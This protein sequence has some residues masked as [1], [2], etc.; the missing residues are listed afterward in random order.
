MRLLR[1]HRNPKCAILV[2]CIVLSN[3]LLWL[4]ALE[5]FT[6]PLVNYILADLDPDFPPIGNSDGAVQIHSITK[7]ISSSSKDNTNATL[8][9]AE[10]TEN[11]IVAGLG[12]VLLLSSLNAECRRRGS[13]RHLWAHVAYLWQDYADHVV[14]NF[15]GTAG[16]VSKEGAVV[17]GPQGLNPSNKNVYTNGVKAGGFNY[18]PSLAQEMVAAGIDIISTANNHAFDR[19]LNGIE[20]TIQVIRQQ[21]AV[22]VGTLPAGQRANASWEKWFTVS[23]TKGVRI[24]WIGC[25]ELLC[26]TCRPGLAV[27]EERVQQQ[28]LFCN[29]VPRLIRYIL[30]QKAADAII[31]AAHWG[32]QFKDT[33][34]KKVVEL[35]KEILEAGAT[36]IIGNHAHVMQNARHYR[37]RDGRN[38]YVFY[39]LGSLTSGLGSHRIQFKRRA[40]AVA[41]LEIGKKDGADAYEVVEVKYTPICEIWVSQRL[42]QMV[43]TTNVA[44]NGCKREENWAKKCLGSAAFVRA[45]PEAAN[46]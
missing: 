30:E 27:K 25:T 40:S 31:V 1:W 28:V 23:R 2:L 35:G 14:A 29:K 21:G 12:D 3:L 13:C 39:S 20:Q 7:S 19:G 16:R 32:A 11:V 5:S 17:L 42:R 24:A 18:H 45:P 33:A 22:Q 38:A 37:T 8:T 34:S 10:D 26:A 36:A 43:P 6:L 9:K 46:A 4:Q 15:E 44:S 41:F